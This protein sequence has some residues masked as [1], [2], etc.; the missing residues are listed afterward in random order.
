MEED[1]SVALELVCLVFNIRKEVC[2]VLNS[3]LCLLK[4][5]DKR[6]RNMLVLILDTRLKSLRLMFSFIGHDQG[7]T[8]TMSL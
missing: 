5:F 2:G 3:F 4:K 1:F 8:I 7:I 6:T